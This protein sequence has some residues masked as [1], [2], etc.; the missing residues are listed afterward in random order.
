MRQGE[1]LLVGLAWGAATA[2]IAYA[3]IRVLDRAV[4]PEPNPAMLIWSE[5]SSFLWRA[6]IALYA[7]GLG[8][9][10]GWALAGR[11]PAA[12][13]RALPAAI[14]AAAAALAVQGAIWP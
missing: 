12:S 2:V 14:T 4:F 3:L 8:V 7:G 11:A 5:R 6:A 10:G 9:F 1:R 13:A